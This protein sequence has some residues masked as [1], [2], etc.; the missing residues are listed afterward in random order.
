MFAECYRQRLPSEDR[1]IKTGRVANGCSYR[2]LKSFSTKLFDGLR[3]GLHHTSRVLLCSYMVRTSR[4]KAQK[5]DCSVSHSQLSMERT[6]RI[7]SIHSVPCA[8][9]KSLERLPGMARVKVHLLTT[10]WSMVHYTDV[11]VN[12][13][14]A[15]PDFNTKKLISGL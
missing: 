6:T 14:Q 13:S 5:L 3:P 10:G 12:H 4:L 2:I 15:K 7:V 11:Y 1:K 9:Y 8:C